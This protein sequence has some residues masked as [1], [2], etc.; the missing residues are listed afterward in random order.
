[1]GS[2]TAALWCLSQ[3]RFKTL[4][5]VNSN[6]Y[7]LF[8]AGTR[9]LSF[10]LDFMAA[11][12]TLM[13]ALF[14]VLSDIDQGSKGLALSYTIQVGVS[15]D[16]WSGACV[17]T[18]NAAL[19]DL[20]LWLS[21]LAAH[22]PAAVRGADGHRG[23]GQVQLCGAAAG[24]HQSKAKEMPVDQRSGTFVS[25]RCRWCSCSEM[26]RLQTFVSDRFV[27][28]RLPNTRRT[29]TFQTSGRGKGPSPSRT[30]R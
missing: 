26:F 29:W 27:T 3:S 30:T 15:S 25:W 21:A 9:W 18:L 14:A 2:L 13:V 23:G 24:I 22:R 20:L 4:T 10:W 19:N 7:F 1:M 6:H 8:N 16:E 12:M 28:L 17:E 5:D 11:T